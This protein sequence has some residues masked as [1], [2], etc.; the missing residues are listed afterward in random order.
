MRRVLLTVHKFFPEH[1]AG[2]EVLTL[3]VAQELQRRN[4]ETLVVTADPPDIDARHS[5]G[6]DTV[7]Y[8]YEGVKVHAVREP[9][10]LRG[11]TFRHEF[12]HP[13]IGEHFGSLLRQFKPDLVHIFHAENL[14]GEIV[15]QARRQQV[16]I[17]CSLTDFWFVCPVVQLKRPDGAL[18]RGPS[19]LA[20]N[21]LT[22]YTP[23]LFPPV[24]QIAEAVEKK[25]PQLAK[26]LSALPPFARKLAIDGIATTFRAV[27]L[28][29]AVT[30]TMQRPSFLRQAANA[31]DAIMVPTSL[32]RDIFVEN[33]IRSELI[34][35]VHFGLDTSQ[36]V[37][38]QE[39][40][41]SDLVR[42]GFIG[43]MFEHKGIDL[44]ISAFHRLPPQVSAQLIIY[45]DPNQFPE[46]GQQMVDLAKDGRNADKIKFFGTFPNALL[47]EVLENIDILTVPS[48]WYEN[49]PLVI[50]SAFATKTPILATDLGGMSE[51]VKHNVN[52]LLFKL[53][54]V[55][56]LHEQLQR[57]VDD[58]ELLPALR[59]G[60]KPERTVQEMVDDIEAVY[61]T[62]LNRR[63]GKNAQPTPR[64][65]ESVIS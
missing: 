15:H 29:P 40:S 16:P 51:L 42:I 23:Q 33:G 5:V 22:C 7:D 30:A 58:K 60:I 20:A 38:H 50:Q 41:K 54:D 14:S 10:R 31:V 9:L 13:Q 56:S 17:V 11:Y 27:K 46:Y 65:G 8:E 28:P 47:G 21:C 62:V 6:D 37:Q 3:K 24:E 4:Y 19:A 12:S 57:I 59:A 61:E 52:G 53:N 35:K 64:A 43:T 39:K 44:L 18:C 34:S 2:T 32:M 26:Q 36:L 49:T 63:Q 45:G 48:R 25:L 55:A 1:R